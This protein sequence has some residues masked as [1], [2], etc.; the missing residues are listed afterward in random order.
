VV[1]IIISIFCLFF[2]K[3]ASAETAPA[4]NVNPKECID[5]HSRLTPQIVKEFKSGAMGKFFRQSK[6]IPKEIKEPD[7]ADCHGSDHTTITK[8]HGRVPDETCGSCHM[9]E[10]QQHSNGGHTRE[11]AGTSWEKLMNSNDYLLLPAEIRN[12]SCESCHAVSGATDRKYWDEKNNE[13][14]DGGS[15]FLRNGC[16]SCHLRHSFNTERARKPAACMQCHSGGHSSDYEAYI[17]SPHGEI[18]LNNTNESDAPGCITCHMLKPADSKYT[19]S[20]NMSINGDAEFISLCSRCHETSFVERNYSEINS[21][22]KYIDNL[23][24]TNREFNEFLSSTGWLDKKEKNLKSILWAVQIKGFIYQ[25]PNTTEIISAYNTART[26]IFHHSNPKIYR[27]GVD[28]LH[29]NLNSL[30]DWNK[31]EKSLSRLNFYVKVAFLMGLAAIFLIIIIPKR[32]RSRS[33]IE[34]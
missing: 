25:I 8:S 24:L 28:K 34:L 10:Y 2:L 12:G 5:C 14:T 19:I 13:Y 33:S 31:T 18:S 27:D 20:H 22:I 16:D 7:C 9:N 26:G 4:G 6:N 15:L 3:L 23:L 21:Y 32:K 11:N 17:L 29:N 30:A 1:K